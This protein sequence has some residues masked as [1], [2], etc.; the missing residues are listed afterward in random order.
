M[1]IVQISQITNRKGLQT[2]LPQLAGAELGWSLDQRRLWIGNGT[3]A[4]GAPAVGNTEILTE[5]SDVLE[6]SAAYT[7]KGQAAGYTV[8]TGATPSSPV[9]QDLQGWFD[10]W[11][12]VKDFGAV[13][14]GV[15]D[16]TAAINRALYQIYCREVNPQIRRALFFPAGVYRVSNTILIPSYATLYG[17]GPDNSVI[18]LDDITDDST[19]NA[20]VARTADSL[21][22]YGANIG[23]NGATTPIYINITNL[24]FK[25]NDPTT[26]VFLV[27]D[28]TNCRFESTGFYG[29]MTTGDLGV[30]TND[31]AGVRF[32]STDTLVSSAIVFDSC[33]FSGTVFGM[34][35]ATGIS[36][37]EQL[38]KGIAVNNSDF[39]VL[40][41]GIA[42]GVETVGLNGGTTGFRITNNRF[43]SIYA[44]GIIIGNVSLNA[45]GYNIFYDVGNHFEGLTKPYTSII[46]ITSDN[47]VSLGD[48]FA[49]TDLYAST[50]NPG[51]SYPRVI[52]NNSSSIA[53]TNS[54][55]LAVGTYVRESGQVFTLTAGASAQT[56]LTVD[57]NL[58]KAF[59][60]NY[61]I[62]RDTAVRTGVLTVTA[63]S[64]TSPGVNDDYTENATTGITLAVTQASTTI[65]VKYSATA[66]NNGSLTYS[67]AHLA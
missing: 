28:A 33:Y 5:F 61:T 6:L 41:T 52:L 58:I 21:Q 24:G 19:L 54:N 23:S 46:N 42:T 20:Y 16:D 14:D 18:A 22:Q 8:Q 47:N 15:T 25:N 1:A 59:T 43:D 29:P 9:L 49:R 32:A 7:Y 30:Q 50:I 48:M 4:E 60:I 51:T 56:I 35:T 37:T 11:A 44:E 45:T 17:E 66:G 55:Q 64:A 12:T 3:L 36:G 26:D 2:D 63:D 31:T 39:N 53:I 27:E 34:N 10:Q 38:V 13:G 65:S 57:T 67:L 40:N 62:V